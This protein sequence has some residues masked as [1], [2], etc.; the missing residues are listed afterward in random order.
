MRKA[1]NSWM[2]MITLIAIITLIAGY[3]SFELQRGWHEE[4]IE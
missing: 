1:L 2:M 3:V 4:N